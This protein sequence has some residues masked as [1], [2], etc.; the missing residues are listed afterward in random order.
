MISFRYFGSN[1][2]N[3]KKVLVEIKSTKTY[4]DCLKDF[5]YYSCNNENKTIPYSTLKS[6]AKDG[7]FSK[8]YG[9]KITYV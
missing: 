6:I 4:Y 9:V 5:Y 3:A 8:K 2:P 1:N 7:R